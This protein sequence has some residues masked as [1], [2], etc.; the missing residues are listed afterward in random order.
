[1]SR[2]AIFRV[3]LT[4]LLLLPAAAAPVPAQDTEG[5]EAGPE[6]EDLRQAIR[7][8]FSNRLRQELALTDEQMSAI[9]PQVEELEQSRNG[10]RRERRETVRRLTQ[11]LQRGASDAE[12]Q[13]LLDRLDTI[14]QDQRK[15]E[16]TA[17]AR[18]DEQLSVRQRVQFR[19]FIERFRKAMQQR[20]EEFRGD[21]PPRRGRYGPRRPG[22]RRP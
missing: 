3:L 6:G 11:G 13:Q 5:P 21:G 12:L 1:M 15:V 22:A 14:E 18:I 7:R 8:H 4:L 20:I 16:R 2:A 9:L 10:M 19:F 17:M